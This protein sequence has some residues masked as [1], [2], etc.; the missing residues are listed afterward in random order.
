MFLLETPLH[1]PKV[2]VW[3]TVSEI[4]NIDSYFFKEN[5]RRV[6]CCT[7][8]PIMSLENKWWIAADHKGMIFASKLVPLKEKMVVLEIFAH[9][10]VSNLQESQV[11]IVTPCIYKTFPLC[12]FPVRC[13][14]EGILCLYYLTFYPHSNS[15]NKNFTKVIQLLSQ[16]Y[17]MFA[18]I[19][20]ITNA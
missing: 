9:T 4:C 15:C 11:F 16:Y 19:S 20:K 5:K 17:I 10:S 13:I 2:T 18:N 14:E 6:K 1:A 8:W 7:I 3:C 12:D